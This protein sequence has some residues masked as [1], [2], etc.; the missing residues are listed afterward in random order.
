MASPALGLA[1]VLGDDAIE[2]DM[3]EVPLALA[4]PLLQALARKLGEAARPGEGVPPPPGLRV[5][6]GV[7]EPPPLVLL[8]APLAL[9][10]EQE[11]RL[12][13]EEND[14]EAVRE[15]EGGAEAVAE[16]EAA[17][18][19]VAGA[20]SVPALLSEAEDEGVIE[21]CALVLALSSGL[22]LTLAVACS[23]GVPVPSATVAV[24]LG[25]NEPLALGEGVSEGETNEEALTA[26]L[27][28]PNHGGEAVG[29]RGLGERLPVA[30]PP[31]G[32]G[33]PTLALAVTVMGA[34]RAALEEAVGVEL[35]QAVSDCEDDPVAEPQLE[36]EVEVEREG[37][38]E[39]E[40]EVPPLPLAKERVDKGVAQVVALDVRQ[41]EKVDVTVRE[42]EADDAQLPEPVPLPPLLLAVGKICVPVATGEG[43]D[44]ALGLKAVLCE[45]PLLRVAGMD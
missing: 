38:G 37:E 1:G 9:P 27:P 16:S 14:A 10:V 12:V 43:E 30:V 39:R 34:L 19:G 24:E 25:E 35:A 20:L 6:P 45:A 21:G 18:L 4:L 42:A 36:D 28:L 11:D 3:G 15:D 17:A 7:P 26:P 41:G 8:S 40:T 23:S 29:N 32:L 13:R 22:P 2:A 5:S 44:T 33:A 31:V